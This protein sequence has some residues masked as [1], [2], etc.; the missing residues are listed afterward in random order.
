MSAGDAR[1]AEGTISDV[2]MAA[3]G[4]SFSYPTVQWVGVFASLL[5]HQ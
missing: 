5:W 1:E 4:H 3:L 2:Q